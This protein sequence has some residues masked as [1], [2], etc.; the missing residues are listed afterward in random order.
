MPG[1]QEGG[2]NTGVYGGTGQE[3]LN[4]TYIDGMPVSTISAQGD[5]TPV[6][7]A[8]SVDAVDQFQVKTNGA[9]VSFG[10][11]GVT[12][13]TIKA[14]GDRMH[15]TVFDYI[16]NTAFD[17]WGYFSKVPGANGYAVKPGE[18][19][20]SYGG[21]LGGPIIK[22]K[23]FYFGTY[24]GFHYTKISN[25][26]QYLHS[27]QRYASGRGD[28]TDA[29]GTGDATQ[30]NMAGI[31]DPNHGLTPSV[32]RPTQRCADIQRNSAE[33]TLQHLA[34][35]GRGSSGPDQS[36]DREQLSRGPPA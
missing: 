5:P 10:G 33:R 27:C 34:E 4:Q 17:T 11:A 29:F 7:N 35:D 36:F 22:G 3:Y 31:F 14:G 2:G 8:V 18:H 12:N 6:R 19:Q 16:R 20:N 25:T 15:G 24:E 21:S 23:L 26:P 9:S 28:F 32:P 1:V 30:P 13:Y